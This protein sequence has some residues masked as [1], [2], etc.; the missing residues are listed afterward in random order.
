MPTDFIN[1]VINQRHA[2]YQTPQ[3]CIFALIQQT[4]GDDPVSHD[5]V[6]RN[7]HE[8]RLR[9]VDMLRADLQSVS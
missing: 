6:R 8:R 3:A 4:T 9:V 2:A 5:C 7:D 1:H